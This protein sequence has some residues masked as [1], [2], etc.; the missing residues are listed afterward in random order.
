LVKVLSVT[1]ERKTLCK[2]EKIHC[3]SIW[4]FRKGLQECDDDREMFVAMISTQEQ[5]NLV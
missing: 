2:N 1:E 3:P 4:M 5:R